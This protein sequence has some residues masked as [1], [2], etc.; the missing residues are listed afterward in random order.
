MKSGKI[1]ALVV[2]PFPLWGMVKTFEHL[3]KTG[4]LSINL[5]WILLIWLA[6]G[7]W[8]HRPRAY[9]NLRR[10]LWFLFVWTLFW[11]FFAFS[12]FDFYK[13]W[14]PGFTIGEIILS[15]VFSLIAIGAVLYYTETDKVLA[16]FQIEK[17]KKKIIA[18]EF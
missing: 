15:F 14:F 9:R 3:H 13:R 2:L 10:I 6:I 4:N 1:L 7:L 16:D 18:E 11:S 5:I 8:K 12:G 17:P